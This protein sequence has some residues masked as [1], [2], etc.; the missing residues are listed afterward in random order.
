MY[1][2]RPNDN[3]NPQLQGKFFI[4]ELYL[5]EWQLSMAEID[6]V[7]HEIGEFIG[8]TIERPHETINSPIWGISRNYVG[9]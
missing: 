8:R 4:D 9:Q 1:L 7:L 2:A 5:F 3:I 6:A